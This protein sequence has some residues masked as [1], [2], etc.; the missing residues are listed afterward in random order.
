[1]M[2]ALEWCSTPAGTALTHN[3]YT[4]LERL[5][6]NKRSSLFDLVVSDEESDKLDL[7]SQQ[8]FTAWSNTFEQQISLSKWRTLR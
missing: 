6:R 3:S 8:A 7:F 1:M 4:K 5:A 2:G